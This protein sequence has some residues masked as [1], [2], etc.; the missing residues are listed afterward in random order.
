MPGPAGDRR[1]DAPWHELDRRSPAVTAF[2]VAGIAFASAVP[3]FV[4]VRDNGL[5][6]WQVLAM[7][8]VGFLVVVGGAALVERMR[9]RHTRYRVTDERVELRFSWVVHRLRSVPRDRIRTVDLTANPLLRLFGVVRMQIGTG[10]HGGQNSQLVLNPLDRRLAERLRSELLTRTSPTPAPAE[11]PEEAG[12][13]AG[14]VAPI[15]ELRWSWIRYAP[16]SVTT[17]IL[18]A[19]AFGALLQ[20]SDWLG[21]RETVIGEAGEL[22]RDMP[23]PALIGLVVAVGVVVG[24]VGSLGLFVELWW[25]Y[26]LTGEDGMFRVRRG[27]LTTRSLSL[28]ERRLRGV[29]VVEPIGARTLRA[30]KVDVVAT[31]LR[32][33]GDKERSDPKTVLPAAPIAEAHR[34]AARILGEPR[35]PTESVRLRRH[36]LAARRRRVLRALLA[37]LLPAGVLGLLG[38]P[39]IAWIALAFCL[40]VAVALAL[41]AY[42]NLGHGITGGYLVTRYG[43]ASRRTVA[44]RRSGVIGWTITSS[45]FQRRAGLITLAA[46]TAAQ[47]G[48]YLI[49]DV[50]ASDGLS[51]AE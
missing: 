50:G 24:V 9:W 32:S 18:G 29:E 27:L 10:Q 46:T 35:C 49:R 34:V 31:G 22:L 15:A 5:P 3:A 37:T 12:Q 23:W 4:N 7:F 33:A 47:K 45:P 1:A 25:G 26:R 51:F 43:A 16:V 40:P 39:H 28:D 42:R 13:Q 6:H 44:L 36:P 17:P 48:A 41:D 38:L 20:V 19:A 11:R 14:A 8:T 30:A 2:V 21:L